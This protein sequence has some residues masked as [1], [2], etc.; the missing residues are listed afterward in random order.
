MK[1][2]D[3]KKLID[4]FNRIRI[5]EKYRLLSKRVVNWLE[6]DKKE[7][8][9]N[10]IG[11]YCEGCMFSYGSNYCINHCLKDASKQKDN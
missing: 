10:E 2:A 3:R 8:S 4:A 6:D 7:E 5:R 1:Q 9:A 11:T